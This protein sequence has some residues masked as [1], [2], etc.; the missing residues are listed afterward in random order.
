[1]RKLV[2]VV[3]L[4]LA[5]ALT[6]ALG[7][8]S[9][10]GAQFVSPVRVLL[11]VVQQPPEAVCRQRLLN[12]GFESNDAWRMA[13]SP[14]PADYDTSI[15]FAG[16]RSLRS[17]V[18]IGGRDI[19]SYSSGFQD[20]TIPAT[21]AS[22]TVTFWWYPVSEEGS[23]PRAAPARELTAAEQRA[24]TGVADMAADAL[25]AGDFQYAVLADQEGNILQKFIWTRNDARQWE[26]RAFDVAPS[27]RGRTVR[28][29][30]GV[31]SD[32]DGR[33]TSIRVD[34][35]NVVVCRGERTSTPTPTE[36][37]TLT[38]TATLPRR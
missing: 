32:G 21:A 24:L 33:R 31:Y 15:F 3:V 29:L 28:V 26:F 35:A 10:A 16:A 6:A 14:Y 4:V 19:S 9:H 25:A 36:L 2:P 20:V 8:L 34:E 22:A 27:L 38:A 11:P 12:A 5:V 17:G 30:F 13:T 1:M 18:P 37:P 7:A 23:L